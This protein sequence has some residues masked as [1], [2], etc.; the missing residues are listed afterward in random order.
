MCKFVDDK[1]QFMQLIYR[2]SIVLL[3]CLLC[4][5]SNGQT[6]L[7]PVH[8][9]T[10]AMDCNWRTNDDWDLTRRS[11]DS[12]EISL[13]RTAQ[14]YEHIER[15]LSRLPAYSPYLNLLPSVLPVDVPV[16]VFIITSPFGMRRHPI[17]Q[18]SRFHEGI[19]VKAGAGMIVKATASGIVR[20]VGHHPALGVFVRLQH[21]F[22]FETTY[23]HLSKLCVQPGQSVV[24]NQQIGKVGQ[25]GLV[26]GPHLHYTIKKN[27]SI[28]DPFDFCFL[29]RRRIWLYKA[30]SESAVGKS[31][32]TAVESAS[33]AGS[34]PNSRN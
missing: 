25:T 19:D 34:Y 18:Q 3:T 30:N 31:D 9:D 8:M 4:S 1:F 13:L 7:K 23:G 12:L 11:R 27:G 33:S 10:L 32:S 5:E 16:D 6:G 17:Y 2:V 29:L 24:R 26:T 14:T 20:E 28:I 22:G 15:L 21:A